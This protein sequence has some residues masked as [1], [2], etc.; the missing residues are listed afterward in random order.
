MLPSFLQ[1]TGDKEWWDG[2]KGRRIGLRIMKP[3]SE[4]VLTLPPFSLPL[5]TEKNKLHLN[6][7]VLN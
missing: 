6:T 7:N 1:F 5:P 3:W 2:I 4:C